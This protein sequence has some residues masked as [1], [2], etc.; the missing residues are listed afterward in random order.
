MA[1]KEIL[2]LFDEK[3]ARLQSSSLIRF[4]S[5]PGWKLSFDFMTNTPGPDAVLPDLE[6]VESY[7]LNLRL[8]IQDN[9]P[10]SLRNLSKFYETNCHDQ[11]I[12]NKFAELRSIFNSELD[13]AWPFSYN[14]QKLTFRDIFDGFIY[15]KIAHSNVESH[16]I[17]HNLTKHPFGYNL[18]FDYFLR[19]INLVHDILTMISHLNKIAFANLETK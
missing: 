9:E 15:S 12:K 5:K 19:C 8:F 1:P 3:Y 6:L 17:F 13:K 14:N 10:I 11:E 2:E 4:M 18:A 16:K 7:V